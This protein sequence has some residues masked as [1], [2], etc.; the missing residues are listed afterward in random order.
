MSRNKWGLSVS[1]H[2]FVLKFPILF[3]CGSEKRWFSRALRMADD[4][5][6][7]LKQRAVL[8]RQHDKVI[9]LVVTWEN[10]GNSVVQIIY[11]V[12]CTICTIPATMKYVRDVRA[13]IIPT[14][15]SCVSFICYLWNT[16]FSLYRVAR[17]HFQ[18]TDLN[19]QLSQSRYYCRT[20]T[21]T[22]FFCSTMNFSL[23]LDSD[24]YD[25]SNELEN[26]VLHIHI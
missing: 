19:C 20:L 23:Y 17:D 13:I 24:V 26:E 3:F 18:V 22:I 2:I 5:F 6:T 8:K 21:W 9:S 7:H 16:N 15:F 25:T 1:V 10:S 4:N 11:P 12:I 14:F